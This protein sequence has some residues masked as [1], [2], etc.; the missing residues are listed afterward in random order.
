MATTKTPVLTEIQRAA[1]LAVQARRAEASLSWSYGQ[2]DACK[3]IAEAAKAF[4][5]TGADWRKFEAEGTNGF[6]GNASQF[7]QVLEKLADDDDLKLEP[8]KS[9]SDY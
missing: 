1:C 2:A 7:R 8:A 9:A 4:A 6:L 3:A 5:K